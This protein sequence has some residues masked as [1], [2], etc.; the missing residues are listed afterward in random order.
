MKTTSPASIDVSI[1]V[2]CRN[3][4]RHIDEFLKSLLRQELDGITWEA[5]IVD[6]MSD[7]GTRSVIED[8]CHDYPVRLLHNREQ[9]V[10]TSLNKAI[11]EAR[12]RYILRMDVHTVYAPDYVR[13]CLQTAGTTGADNVGG[14]WLPKGQGYRGRAIAAVFQASFGTGAAKGHDTNYEGPVDTVY[15]G[16]WPRE[17]FERVGLFDPQLV[18]NQDDEFNV[19]LQRSG[20]RVWQSPN[21]VSF[22]HP[23]CSLKDL[24]RQYMQYGYWKVAVIRKHRLPASLR[25][26]IPGIFVAAHGVMALATLLLLLAGFPRAGAASASL[27]AA[28]ICLYLTCC[29]AASIAAAGKHGWDLLPVLPGVFATYHFSYGFGFLLGIFHFRRTANSYA[30]KPAFT[31]LTR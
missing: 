14:P 28:L 6:G 4:Q 23:R 30:A 13:Q 25:H 22:Y 12:G 10:S 26:L 8:Y 1:V 2:P 21:I 17:V 31:E 9:I 19:R 27:W 29:L 7:D 3:E 11:T 5:L 20:G 18:R 24:F 16:C 15:L